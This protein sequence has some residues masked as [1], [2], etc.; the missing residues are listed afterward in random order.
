M[1]LLIRHADYRQEI[2]SGFLE[3]QY[4]GVCRLYF[5]CHPSSRL[6]SVDAGRGLQRW[7]NVG[8]SD[9]IYITFMLADVLFTGSPSDLNVYGPIGCCGTESSATCAPTDNIG[10]LNEWARE[11]CASSVM[12]ALTNIHTWIQKSPTK[13]MLG[14]ATALLPLTPCQTLLSRIGG[15]RIRLQRH[16]RAI[17]NAM[18][19]QI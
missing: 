11:H 17:W 13:S 15:T 18:K 14:R 1:T 5:R 10:D 2:L 9:V 8:R 19:S 12:F 7:V 3:V 4:G 16:P 6:P